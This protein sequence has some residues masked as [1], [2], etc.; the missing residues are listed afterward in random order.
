[1]KWIGPSRQAATK[2]Q[3]GL[4]RVFVLVSELVVTHCLQI[5]NWPRLKQPRNHTKYHECFCDPVFR[6]VLVSH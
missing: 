5:D 6:Q 2:I 4:R 1:M 3:I